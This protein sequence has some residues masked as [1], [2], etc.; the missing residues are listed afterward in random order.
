M[1]DAPTRS[2]PPAGDPTADPPDGLT[3]DISDPTADAPGSPGGG[4]A[5]VA[6]PGCELLE[7]V[8]SGG[9]GIVY[10]ARESDEKSVRVRGL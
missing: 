5:V 7:E 9:M 6:P 3:R 1:S 8:G 4:V 10:R 2:L